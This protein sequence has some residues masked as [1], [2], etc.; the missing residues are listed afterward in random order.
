[1]T[2][3]TADRHTQERVGNE[4]SFPILANTLCHAGGLAT[5][6]AAG[7]VR[8]GTVDGLSAGSVAVGRFCRQYDNRTGTT[9]LSAATVAQ[10]ESGIFH[11]DND[12]VAPVTTASL[13]RTCYVLD[14]QTVSASSAVNTR[15]IAG[16]VMDVD[17]TGIWVASGVSTQASTVTEASVPVYVGT[18]AMA[19]ASNGVLR[20][21]AT[22]AGVINSFGTVLS[23]ALATGD[24]TLT[25]AINGTGVTGG[26][27]TL[28]SAGSAANVAKI[29]TPS[30]AN[31]FVAG[32][33]ITLTV[34]GA[35]TGS[36]TAA[37]TLNLTEA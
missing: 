30:A 34:G 27:Q 9:S 13:R 31:S 16:I 6:T 7:Y 17:A 22:R 2:A 18:V 15:T 5:V 10:V 26:A 21:V 32:D 24:A 28:P 36:A 20:Y 19:A 14:D 11:W 23:A 1:M 4:Y 12:T 37:V 33:V 25:C 8:P 29:T 35:A 3:L